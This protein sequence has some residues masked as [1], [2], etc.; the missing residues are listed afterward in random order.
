M[1][2]SLAWIRARLDRVGMTLSCLCAVHCVAT[3]VIVAGLGLGGGFL[4]NPAIHRIGLA[5][6]IVIAAI[7]IGAGARRHGRRETVLL[8][9]VGLSLMATGLF[10]PHGV[11]EAALTIPG[12]CVVLLAHVL[13]VRHLHRCNLRPS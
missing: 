7:A 11:V 12:V 1:S 13:N 8:A 4:L 3:L 10:V 9:G 5:L 6:A 2:S